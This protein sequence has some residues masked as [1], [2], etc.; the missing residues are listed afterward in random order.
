VRARRKC[1]GVEPSRRRGIAVNHLASRDRREDRSFSLFDSGQQVDSPY[2]YAELIHCKADC[3][4]QR[5]E[6]HP[7]RSTGWSSHCMCDGRL[8]FLRVTYS[9][10]SGTWLLKK[11]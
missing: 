5:I 7:E 6:Q 8:H 9:S 11:S 1:D 2:Q 3:T 10:D 4:V